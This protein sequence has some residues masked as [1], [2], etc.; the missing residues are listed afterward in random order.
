[1]TSPKR[2]V[3]EDK[4]QESARKKLERDQLLQ[5]EDNSIEKQKQTIQEKRRLATRAPWFIPEPVSVVNTLTESKAGTKSRA[6]RSVKAMYAEFEAKRLKELKQEKPSLRFTQMIDQ[7]Q[8]EF[9]R[10]C[11]NTLNKTN[12]FYLVNKAIAT[13]RRAEIQ[14]TAERKLAV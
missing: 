4:K 2:Q 8:K 9:E 7:I 6:D 1:M 10:S 3:E 14:D 13:S 5:A 12:V 11:S